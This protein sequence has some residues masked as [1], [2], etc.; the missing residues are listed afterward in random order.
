MD[1]PRSTGGEDN[2]GIPDDLRCKRSD[3]KQ[4]RCTAMSMPD[5][6]VCEKHYIQA[7]KRAANSAMRASM[8]KARRKSLGESDIYLE[9]KSD[10]MD[11]PL[12]SQFGD[13]S[14]SASG[15]KYKEKLSKNRVNHSP[16]MT[17]MRSFS[18]HNSVRSTDDIDRDGSEYEESRQSP[19]P[20]AMES[21][22]GRSRKMFDSSPV[23][24]SSGGSSE[25]SDDNGEQP[26][27][28]CRR[29]DRDRVIWC[30]KCRRRGY[31]DSCIATWYSDIPVEE[32]ER[33]CP[34][35]RGS[36]SCRVC[37]R[38]DNLIKARIREIPAQ[39][40]LQYLYCVLSSVLPVVKQIHREQCSEVELEKR[41]R[42]N[43]IDLART[44]LNADEQMCCNFCRTPIIDYHRH[45]MRCSYDLCLNCCK[46]I[47]EASKLSVNGE[48][49][50][51]A[52]GSSD[53]EVVSVQEM[54]NVQLNS[55]KKFSGWKANSNGSLPCAPKKY[56]GC[57]SPLLVLKRI[58][59]MNWVAKLVKN[60]EEMVGG[61]K[62]CNS[63]SP[64]KNGIDLRLCQAAQRTNDSDNLLYNPSSE[65]IKREGIG[66]FRMHWRRGEPI[67]IKEVCDIST[68]SIW[69]PMVVWRGIKE[70]AEE[71]M[72]DDNRTVKAIDCS[73]WTEIDIEPREFIQGYFDGRINENG[74]PQLLKLKDWPSPSASE[75]FLLY[76]RPDFISKLPLLEF[77]HSKWGL[78]NVAAKLPHYSLQNDVGLKIFIS[79]GTVEELGQGDSTNN[80]HLNMR[81]MVFLLVHIHD[82]K[83]KDGQTRKIEKMQMAVVES[84]S[85]ES[86]GSPEVHLDR[87]G[88]PK[89]S[90][91]G[92][93]G[94][95]VKVDSDNH[96]KTV[97]QEIE[98]N[99]IVEEE[100]VNHED[101]NIVSGNAP[102]KPKAGA[103]WDVFRRQDVPKLIEY[104]GSHWKEFG[105]TDD[106]ISDSVPWPLYTDAIY[107]DGHHKIKLKEE[108]GV[109]PW[110]FEQH[111][112]EAAF[113]PAGCP[114]Q[115]RHLQST[116]QL[117][118]DFLSPESLGEAVR[119]A[120]EIRGLPNDHEA[121]LQILEVGKISLYAASSAIKEVQKLVLDPKLGPELGFEDPNLTALVSQNLESMVKRRQI[122]CI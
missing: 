65:D 73:D 32:I 4:W 62:T 113:I 84:D 46:D 60:V 69:D 7:K 58:F 55:F 87:G 13:Y 122:T 97:D 38:G 51:I 54:S 20:S 26:C 63:G 116:V 94:S 40:K 12:S 2:V 36:C 8:K 21:S 85:K 89:L 47:R 52:G 103:L 5:K 27:H 91:S 86:C 121:K 39:D 96:E 102:E 68:M 23:T 98:T 67:I 9:S 83:L 74:W 53:N 75:E 59:K 17:S 49:N 45:C 115:V 50:Q 109:E 10:D 110:T 22:R 66:D 106:A 11:L 35:C 82:V 41:L 33:V 112:G 72:K 120:E 80:L 92:N 119:L 105:N 44:K 118:L 99:F 93:D 3:G 111:L 31:C 70:T 78:L 37:L 61:C 76:Q 24:E 107:L 29:N 16:E 100:A 117:G 19:P 34:A 95:E 6:T 57:G 108:F 18:T 71:K 114:V 56:G 64:K 42:G 25:P 30:L 43:E 81:D 14:G 15:K 79:Y 88:S 48:M 90:P 101:L 77:F 28:Q 104:I 1:H